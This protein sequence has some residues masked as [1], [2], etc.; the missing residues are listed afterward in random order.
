MIESAQKRRFAVEV[1]RRLREAGH[2]AY[3]AGGCVRDE[4]LGRTPKDFDVA[5]SAAPPQVRELFGHRRTLA[6]GAAFGVIT[7]RG[8]RAAGM[9]EVATFRQDSP[10]SDGRRPDH[11]TFSSAAEDALRRDF[12]IN[13]L[14]YDP[15]ERRVI[16]FVGGQEDLAR[17]V[18]RAIGPPQ[19]R[20]AEDKLRMLRAVRFTAAFDFALDPQTAAA[21]REMAPEITVVSP[22]RIA[23]EMRRMLTE[24]GR[25]EAVRLL[26]DVGLAP[27][28]LPE[29][30]AGGDL[31]LRCLESAL[32]L[33]GRLREPGFPLALAA[34]VCQ[35]VDAE[36]TRQIGLRWRL[37]NQEI[38]QSAWLV[39]H[40]DDL[41]GARTAPW[42]RLQPI[43]IHPWIDDLM[44]L[45]EAASPQGPDVAAYC[46]E[47]LRQP[48]ETLDPPPLA[49]GNDL[50]AC[51]IP[52]G[53]LYKILLQR[54]RDE[55]LDGRLHS[56]ADA[57]ALAGRI[58]RDYPSS[59]ESFTS[60]TRSLS[61]D[62]KQKKRIDVLQSRIQNLRQQLAGA[63]KQM[64][65]PQEVKNLENQL[66]AAD[67]ELAK[68]KEG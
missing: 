27:A 57:Q 22:E 40:R 33:L 65:D 54:I 66:A 21:I 43:L 60:Q 4:L 64:D 48:R 58:V 68:T 29:I 47:L 18:V 26:V 8:P 42:S 51:G 28:V 24:A 13:G 50:R 17:R 39:A 37:S 15:I 10:T 61:M 9:I 11:V 25:V 35:L 23:M 5:T 12:T 34:I 32:A 36:A 46:R 52:P 1:V 16:D 59:T 55:Q 56:K 62:K 19:A 67:A 2:E 49:T 45:D 14:F 63:R 41:A 3:W 30:M 6:I 38:E 53:P 44:A 7:V 20:F 31:G